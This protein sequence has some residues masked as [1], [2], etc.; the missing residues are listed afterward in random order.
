MEKAKMSRSVKTEFLVTS[1]LT[2]YWINSPW[3]VTK[4]GKEKARYEHKL[5]IGGYSGIN[6]LP[7]QFRKQENKR[8]RG[9][10][11]HE[12]QRGVREV[13]YQP[14][15]STWNCKDSNSWGWW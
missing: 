13:D 15:M 6:A 9:R 8:R 4:T 5:R 14:N 3:Y 12:M 7:K 11:K 10:D 2:A 1:S